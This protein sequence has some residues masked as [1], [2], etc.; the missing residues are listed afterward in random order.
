V[1]ALVGI[2]RFVPRWASAWIQAARPK[3][4]TAAAA[5]VLVGAGLAKAHGTF[6]LFPVVAAFAGAVL[7]QIGTNLANDY[8]DFVRGPIR[9]TGSARCA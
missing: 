3:T 1:A 7:I 8:Y 2:G 5:P 9:R 6:A 4:L